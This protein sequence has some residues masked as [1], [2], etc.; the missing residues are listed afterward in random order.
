MPN[1]TC[2]RRNELGAYGHS[3]QEKD[4]WDKDSTC[5]YCG[6][7]NPDVLM[8]HL[9]AGDVKLGPTDKNYKVYVEGIPDPDAGKPTIY[10][11]ANFEK[12]EEGWVKV[13]PENI[14]SLP[15]SKWQ[16]ENWNDGKHWVKV[17][18]RNALMHH[19]FYFQHFGDDQKNRFVELLNKKCL[20]IAYPGHFYRLPYFCK[21][22]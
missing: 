4:T 13:T 10:S 19:K 20:N 22:I 2:P 8:S 21:I 6:S 7:L 5:S 9:E 14:D 1:F 11:S 15:L 12:T 3:E 17:E 18:P 16:R